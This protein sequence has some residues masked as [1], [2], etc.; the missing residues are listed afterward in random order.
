MALSPAVHDAVQ[1]LKEATSMAR[2]DLTFLRERSYHLHRVVESLL[3]RAS[4]SGA[5][6]LIF[7][8]ISHSAPRSDVW[9]F[10]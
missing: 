6:R 5:L 8:P 3:D 2:P 10:F 7:P 9:F 4:L 1:G